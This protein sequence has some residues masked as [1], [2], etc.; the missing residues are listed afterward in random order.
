MR[1]AVVDSG[2]DVTHE[3]LKNKI[4]ATYNVV[5][6]NAPMRDTIGHGTFVAGVAAAQTNNAVG[7]AGAGYDTKILAAKITDDD[8]YV[9]IDDE[10]AG[11]KWAATHG[12]DI[13]NLS[14]GGPDSSAAEKAAVQYAQRRGVLVVAAAGNDGVAD[15][16]Y[17]AAYPGVI[18]VGATNTRTHARAA[19]SNYGSWVTVAAPGVGIYSTVPK[20]HTDYFDSATGYASGDGTSFSLRWWPVRRRCSR[21]RTRP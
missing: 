12:A 9:S 19:F 3:D 17:P 2:I 13:I 5:D 6:R 11:I 21:R 16:E 15:R 20:G 18:A 1:V 14:L 7:V 10:I 4:A 8:G